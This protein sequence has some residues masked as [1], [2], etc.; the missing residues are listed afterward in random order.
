MVRRMGPSYSRTV[1]AGTSHF[2]A[3]VSSGNSAGA[4]RNV[5]HRNKR[6]LRS[7]IQRELTERH[8]VVTDAFVEISEEGGGFRGD[9]GGFAVRSGKGVDGDEGLP[10]GDDQDFDGPR[11]RTG[12]DGGA[13]EALELAELGL[14][15][16][17]E[18]MKIGIGERG[19]GVCGPEAREHLL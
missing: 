9:H 5:S 1:I 7:G 16:L 10:V 3:V 6:F 2:R 18:M 14:D 15:G 13:E 11:K 8:F 4:V 17:L 19:S 12:A